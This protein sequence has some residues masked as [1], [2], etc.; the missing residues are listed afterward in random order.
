[1]T[2]KLALS[3]AQQLALRILAAKLGYSGVSAMMTALA[4]A[5]LARGKG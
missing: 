2:T 5:A 1:M 3:E 4:I